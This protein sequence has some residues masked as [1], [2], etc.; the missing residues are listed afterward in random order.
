MNKSSASIQ[1]QKAVNL[2]VN[3]CLGIL[4]TLITLAILYPMLF[5]VCTSF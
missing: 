5:V 3:I 2:T 1:K 4:I